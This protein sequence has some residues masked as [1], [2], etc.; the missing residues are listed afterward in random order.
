LLRFRIG[1]LLK[2]TTMRAEASIAVNHDDLT[3]GKDLICGECVGSVA[4]V[5]GTHVAIAGAHAT[6]SLLCVG[7]LIS[8]CSGASL[9][10][11]EI[12]T[13]E[14]ST[15]DPEV[16]GTLLATVDTITR[17]IQT[18]ISHYPRAGDAAFLPS[19]TLI[20]A[21]LEDRRFLYEDLTNTVAL[22]LGASPL[23][24]SHPL[25]FSPEKILGRHCAVVGTSGSGKSWSLARVLEQCVSNRGK[26]ILIDPTGEYRT[27]SGAVRHVHIAGG[28]SAD[29]HSTEV[30]LPYYQLTE[31]DL[32]AILKPTNA[33]QITKLRAAIR[34]LKLLNF[35][36]RL[37]LEGNLPKAH[38]HKFP[39]ECALAEYQDDV[40]RPENAFNIHNLPMQIGLECVD[41][42]RSHTESNYWGGLNA[43]DYNDCVPLISKLEDLIQCRELDPII[44]PSDVES[45]IIALEHFLKDPSLHL[46]RV[47]CEHLSTTNRVREVVS[48]ALARHLLGL[49]RAG[50][51]ARSPLILAVD[52][53][54][55][56]LPSTPSL[57]SN[58]YPLEAFNVIAKEGRKYGLTLCVATQRPRDIPDDVLSQVGTF[59]VHRLVSDADRQAIERASGAV[60]HALNTRLPSLSPG[61]AFLLGVDF[62]TPLRLAMA[63][64]ISPPI[65]NGPDFQASWGVVAIQ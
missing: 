5:G 56:M 48:N 10:L 22:E 9:F 50:R 15:T 17:S 28:G 60:N 55:Q 7:D 30:N 43:T 3:P 45:L 46:L 47:S 61:E 1:P 53:A 18:G 2:T 62:H 14:T 31:A 64:P 37:G 36:P 27:L 11:A 49:A 24:L 58:E 57:L 12:T 51:F 13:L 35:D 44:R 25:S 41:P 8:I 19:P 4:E 32:V 23:C 59:V 63:R 26:A 38:R 33:T 40:S 65:S 39:F 20:K 16:R 52:E 34:S 21:F 6:G 54:H 29:A 42:I